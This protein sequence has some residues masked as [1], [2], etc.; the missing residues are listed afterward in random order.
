MKKI[1]E[2][3]V[4]LDTNIQ[5]K[6]KENGCFL[7]KLENF[8]QNNKMEQYIFP[9]SPAHLEDLALSSAVAGGKATEEMI[10]RDLENISKI[11]ANQELLP[12]G[13]YLSEE[14]LEKIES[15]GDISEKIVDIMQKNSYFIGC[16]VMKN[17]R[18]LKDENPSECY[19]KVVGFYDRNL[20]EV[21]PAQRSVCSSIKELSN[22]S[23]EE[24]KREIELIKKEIYSILE[25][26]RMQFVQE[27]LFFVLEI[28][29]E[30]YINKLDRIRHWEGKEDIIVEK[31]N[32][33]ISRTHDITHII[34]A[35]Y[36]KYL[37]TADKVLHQKAKELFE[38][39]DLKTKVILVSNEEF[40]SSLV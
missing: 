30:H 27:N 20:I 21:N 4:Y 37:I 34:Y 8:L 14:D 17:L 2:N 39:F 24:R 5:I 25:N 40:S 16:R 22:C 32:R 13:G 38:L 10:T 3:S 35:S 29:F 33:F 23:K 12:S 7:D 31:K 1:F 36:C 19:K 9:Y 11:S 18:E 28:L 6:I 15:L 26:N